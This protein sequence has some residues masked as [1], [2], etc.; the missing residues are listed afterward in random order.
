MT[1]D[2]LAE[3]IAQFVDEL[4]LPYEDRHVGGE[5]NRAATA[6]FGRVAEEAGLEVTRLPLECID[7]V[8]AD[9]WLAAPDGMFGLEVGPYSP[10]TEVS[11]KLVAAS[12]VEELERLDARGAV[13]L[14][15]G[16]IASQQ[17]LP[18]HY[19]F[20]QLEEH[21]RIVSAVERAKPAVVVAATGRGSDFAGGKYP[22]PLFEDGD[23]EIPSAYMT[24]V[25]GETLLAQAGAE[26]SIVIGSQRTASTAEQLVAAVGPAASPRVVVSAH[27]DSRPDSPGAID[28]ASGVAVLMALAPLL[29]ENPPR[30]L[31]VELVPLNGEDHYAA[32][33]QLAYLERV[34]LDGVVL[35]V[36]VDG[37]GWTGHSTE[38]SFYGCEP[39]A[40]AS[41]L[42]SAGRF[43]GIAEGEPWPMG[44]HMVFAMRDVPAIALTSGDVMLLSRTVAHT[45]LDVPELV[46]ANAL[47]SIVRFIEALVR[48]LDEQVS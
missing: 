34:G 19:P 10:P 45:S 28:N 20:F 1:S 38:I 11:G 6:L 15:H 26:V 21:E 9:A 32:P 33:G 31:R 48:T 7:W 25:A 17:L 42:E 14:L 23:F 5:G 43:D 47:A 46:D 8:H 44:D 40:R 18:K 41:A 36:N 22:F 27:I 37:A 2:P 12:T 39:Q 3:Q 30:G 29:A 13:L 16:E 24:D 35:D 4:C